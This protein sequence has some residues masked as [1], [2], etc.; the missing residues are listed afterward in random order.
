MVFESGLIEKSVGED[1]GVLGDWLH[2]GEGVDIGEVVED[3]YEALEVVSYVGVYLKLQ[4]GFADVVPELV[5]GPVAVPDQ[6]AVE[7][8]TDALYVVVVTLC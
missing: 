5:Y 8:V 1:D 3:L 2:V 6:L 7:I 4:V